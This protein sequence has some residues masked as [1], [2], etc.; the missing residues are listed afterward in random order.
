MKRLLSLV[1]SLLMLLTAAPAAL[2]AGETLPG[3]ADVPADAYYAGYLQTLTDLGAVSPAD[4]GFSPDAPCTRAEFITWLWKLSGETGFSG[5]FSP[6]GRGATALTADDAAKLLTVTAEQTSGE[7]MDFAASVY[8]HLGI[9]LTPAYA[10]TKTPLNVFVEIFDRVDEPSADHERDYVYAGEKDHP[11]DCM[12][13]D[14]FWG[15]RT[16]AGGA[17]AHGGA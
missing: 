6:E 7:Y 3:Y 15:P 13:I 12:L 14:G 2:A 11:L 17:S 4:G 1:L 16:A 8:R 9:D 10:D 5:E